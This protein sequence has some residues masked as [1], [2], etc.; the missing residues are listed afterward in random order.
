MQPQDSPLPKAAPPGG[1]KIF[2][3]GRGVR[4][5]T[6]IRILRELHDI[7]VHRPPT[8]EFLQ[9]QTYLYR[10]TSCVLLV[11]PPNTRQARVI[12]TRAAAQKKIFLLL[13]PQSRQGLAAVVA[14]SPKVLLM[15]LP[16]KPTADQLA[17]EATLFTSFVGELKRELAWATKDTSLRKTA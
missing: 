4:E 11:S 14:A 9:E 7:Q 15:G 12:A 10:N 2:C 6:M 5:Q 17:T 16:A 3:S 8:R 1:L 13:N